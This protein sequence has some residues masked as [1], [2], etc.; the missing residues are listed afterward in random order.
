MAKLLLVD[1]DRATLSWMSAAL[2]AAHHE[3]RVVTGGDGALAVLRTWKPDLIVTDILM[4]EMDGLA[5]TRLAR[6]I[7]DTPVLFLSIAQ[8]RADAVLAGAAGWVQKPA[9]AAEIRSAIDRI[10]GHGAERNT[11][12]VVDDDAETCEL[13]RSFLEPRFR[14]LVAEQGRAALDLLERDAVDLVIA[15]VH[16]P[17]MNGVELIRAMRNRPALR[18][19]PV[20]VQTSDRGILRAPVWS[21]LRVDRVVGKDDFTSWLI[22]EIDARVALNRAPP[23]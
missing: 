16:M 7:Q 12:L 13:Y 10:L 4:P 5:F 6:R 23:P 8:M 14:V 15:D 11:I 1:D 3:V 22:S 2:T 19:V 20:I 9:T 21:E 18:D 17:V